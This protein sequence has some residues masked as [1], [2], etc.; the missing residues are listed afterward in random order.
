MRMLANPT[1]RA[2]AGGLLAG[3][4]LL[5]LGLSVARAET[6]AEQLL[7]GYEKIHTVTCEVRRDIQSGAG[8]MRMLSRVYYQRPDRLHVD[9]SAP[10]PRRIVADGSMF[11]SY[12]EGDPKGF[13]RPIEK[14]DE[15]MLINLRKVPGTA[16]DY[17]LRL[18]GVAETNL[19]ATAEFPVRRGYATPKVFAVLSLDATGRLARL[20]FYAT[21]EMKV[22]TA[23]YDYSAFQEAV[24]GVWIPCLH[25][26]TLTVGGAESQETTRI[27]NLSVNTPVAPALF[28]AAP[29][30]K[31]VKFVS[32]FDEIYQ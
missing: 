21:P 5:G 32:S 31:S 13:S 12:A 4:W 19:P 1:T 16:M 29:F 7:S 15:D 11:Y 28:V 3:A 18:R 14:L 22:R 17:L 25:Q 8:K 20:E 2:R 30:F 24:P 27:N 10:I 23:Q 26:G 9:N 6:A